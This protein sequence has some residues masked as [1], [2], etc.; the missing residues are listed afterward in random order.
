MAIST[1]EV[2]TPEKRTSSPANRKIM[3]ATIVYLDSW[4]YKSN[5]CDTAGSRKPIVAVTNEPV[6]DITFPSWGTLVAIPAAKVAKKLLVKKYQRALVCCAAQSHLFLL[7][8]LK[9]FIKLYSATEFWLLLHIEFWLLLQ[10]WLLLSIVFLIY[11]Y[12]T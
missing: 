5:V 1:I 7:K 12:T 2:Y 10:F 11:I 4:L 6:N 3:F 9:I 8:L